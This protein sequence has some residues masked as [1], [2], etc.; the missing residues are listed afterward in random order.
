MK[1]L[2]YRIKLTAPTIISGTSGDSVTN[3]CLSYIPGTTILGILA[4]R[5]LQQYNDKTEF[6]RLFLRSGLFFQ[7]FVLTKRWVKLYSLS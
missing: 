5:Y 4:G 6:E 3:S 1:S 2:K 7:E